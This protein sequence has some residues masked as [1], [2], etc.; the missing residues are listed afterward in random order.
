MKRKPV[1]VYLIIIALMLFGNKV[2]SQESQDS[3]L[4]LLFIGDVMG[5]SPQI[6]SAYAPEFKSYSYDSVFSRIKPFIEKCD[7]SIA[8]LEVTLAGAPYT[9]YPTF[10]SPD[11]LAVALK[12]AGVD[13]LAT[14]NNH[15]AD[16]G[17]NGITRTINVLNQQAIAHTGTFVS[18]AER[19]SV[20]PL[21][22]EKNGFRIALLNF[23]YG[24][25]GIPVPAPTRVNLIDTAQIRMDYEK[26][27]AL[28]VDEVI[29]FVHWGE[30][31]MS[32]P[33]SQQ[34]QLADYLHHL[35]IR[36]VIGSHPHVL[37]R[38][39]AAFDT[40]STQGR[41][42]VYS[43]GNFVSNQRARY[44]NGGAVA[45][46]K[47]AKRQAKSAITSTGYLLAWVHTPVRQGKKLYQVLPVSQYEQIQGYFS[48]ADHLLF[49][50]FVKDSRELYQR[51]NIN[52]SE[53][54]Y[55]VE[56][57]QWIFP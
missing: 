18:Q 2:Q 23:T 27:R 19:D 57:D 55:D 37:Q 48:A 34:E 51:R 28:C 38:M 31:Y 40:D 47:L 25:N 29:A 50:E 33:N 44:R 54:V 10:S 5:H 24:T 13:V 4:T 6:N 32:E 17:K 1:R 49:S 53:I 21:I 52:V 36:I 41:V 11:E 14:A 35:G 45:Y 8:N 43:L 12:N 22:L 15:S 26:A 9:G 3:T 20:Y 30:E 7:I 39:E 46:V 56:T 42:T 16:R